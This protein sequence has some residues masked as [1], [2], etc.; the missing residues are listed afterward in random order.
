VV[1]SVVGIESEVVFPP[2]YKI[3]NLNENILLRQYG[4]DIGYFTIKNRDYVPFIEKQDINWLLNSGSE[5]NAGDI[6]DW[7]QPNTNELYIFGISFLSDRNMEIRIFNPSSDQLFGIKNQSDNPVTVD[8]S[9]W[10][11]PTITLYT[12][13]PGSGKYGKEFTPAFK[14][15]NPTEYKNKAMKIGVGPGYK[16]DLIPI[17]KPSVYDTV[18]MGIIR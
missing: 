6:S 10:R 3:Y 15:K 14:I 4:E 9:P 1:Q 12:W 13:L 7:L 16:Y 5:Y 2:D 18:D 11:R 17:D 8:M